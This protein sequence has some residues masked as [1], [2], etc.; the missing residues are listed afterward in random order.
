MIITDLIEAICNKLVEKGI[1]TDKEVFD[2]L[3]EVYNNNVTEE[4]KKK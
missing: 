2:M 4:L 3:K 1:F